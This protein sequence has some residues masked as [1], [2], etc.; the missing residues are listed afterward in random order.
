MLDAFVVIVRKK[1]FTSI[2]VKDI[3]YYAQVNRATFYAHFQDKYDI[4]DC[5]I[6]DT[7]MN[8]ISKRIDVEATLNEET[9]RSIIH[10][11]REYLETAN[12]SFRRNHAFTSSLM[13]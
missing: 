3:T 6:I 5:T 12:N 2:S 4:L 8:L 13:E 11:V 9:L 10:F 1:D 7:F